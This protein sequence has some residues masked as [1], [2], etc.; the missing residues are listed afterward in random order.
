MAEREREKYTVCASKHCTANVS[1]LSRRPCHTYATVE[2]PAPVVEGPPVLTPVAEIVP[3]G[4]PA[5]GKPMCL[6]RR[7]VLILMGRVTP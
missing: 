5:A 1:R 2:S 6:G 4:S 3:T 7:C